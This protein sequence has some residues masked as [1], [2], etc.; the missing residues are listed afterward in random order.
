MEKFSIIIN[1][2]MFFSTVIGILSLRLNLLILF[3]ALELILLSVNVN[4]ILIS[5][6]LNDGSGFLVSL[7]ILSVAAAES[8]IGLALLILLFR[9]KNYISF[10]TISL[11]RG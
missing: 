1:F 2:I 3:M 9:I 7:F 6:L 4:F 11:L 8:S 5:N 10:D